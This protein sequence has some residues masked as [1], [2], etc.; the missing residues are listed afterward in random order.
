MC[1]ASPNVAEPGQVELRWSSNASSWRDTIKSHEQYIAECQA[2]GIETPI[3]LGKIN[4]MRI[5]GIMV[6][7]LHALDLGM[8]CHVIANVFVECMASGIWG[9][10]QQVQAEGLRTDL[11]AWYKANK[12]IYRIQGKLTYARIK[13]S[14]DWPKL[15]CKG[16]AARH[17]LAYALHLATMHNDGSMHDQR[18]HAL[19]ALLQRFYDII[20]HSPQFISAEAKQECRQLSKQFMPIYSA[21]S[22]EALAKRIRAWKMP[23]TFHVFQHLLEFQTFINPRYCWCYADE[24]LQSS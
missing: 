8:T 9:G 15:K 11:H 13:S 18:R 23:P 21:L 3:L 19:C 12:A 17:L 4:T 10:N 22:A 14:N 1:N 5:E 6:D 7:V 16:A 20:A 24:D 2:E